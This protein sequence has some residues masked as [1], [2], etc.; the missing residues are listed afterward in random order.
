MKQARKVIFPSS[1]RAAT[2]DGKRTIRGTAS[3]FDAPYLV[4]DWFYEVFRSGAFNKTL[5]DGRNL[6]VLSHHND[7]KPVGSTRAG[8]ARFWVDN[9]GLQYEAVVNPDLAYAVELH[10]QIRSGLLDG[11]SIGFFS[12]EGKEQVTKDWRDG[13]DLVEVMEVDLREASPVTW[14]ASQ[15]TGQPQARAIMAYEDAV[16]IMERRGIVVP[17]EEGIIAENT[18]EEPVGIESDHSAAGSRAII[19]RLRWEQYNLNRRERYYA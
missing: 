16:A 10:E 8:S 14:P 13:K 6:K 4:G 5:S 15:A 12:V 11:S 2:S 7:D 3:V 9:D 19:E 18:T 1:I 17:N